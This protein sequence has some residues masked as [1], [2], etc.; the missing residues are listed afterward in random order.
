MMMDVNRPLRN[1][2]IEDAENLVSSSGQTPNSLRH[3]ATFF[4]TSRGRKEQY[5]DLYTP[6][7]VFDF[8]REVTGYIR[9]CLNG[10]SGNM[11]DIGVSERLIDGRVAPLVQGTLNADRYI[12]K[13]GRQEWETF[14]WKGFRYLQLTFRELTEPI[15]LIEVS[16]NITSYPVEIRG[17]FMADEQLHK[18]WE[19]GRYTLECCMH[20]SYMDTPWREQRQWVGDGYIQLL[21]DLSAHGDL[22]L[23]RKFLR[24]VGQSQRDD[25]T[26]LNAVVGSTMGK[27]P[28]VMPDYSLLWVMAIHD[29]FLHTGD[30]ELLA[31]L[32]PKVERLL[33][34]FALYLTNDNIV[35]ELPYRLF[36]DWAPID[37]KGASA[38]LNAFYYQALKVSSDLARILGKA[39]KAVEY[40]AMADSLKQRIQNIFWDEKKACYVDAYDNEKKSDNIS[41]QTNAL[42]ALYEIAQQGQRE[43]L[44]NLLLHPVEGMTRS[45]PYFTFF[46][47]G[48]LAKLEQWDEAIQLIRTKWGG[49]IDQGATTFWEEWQVHGTYRNGRW[50][51]VPRSH[52]HAWSS[53][54]TYFLSRYVLG[55]EP[56]EPGFRTF[57]FQPGRGS[58]QH[59]DGRYPT[60]RGD[61]LVKWRMEKQGIAAEITVP[62]GLTAIIPNPAG[63]TMRVNGGNNYSVLLRNHV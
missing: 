21:V 28:N 22:R 30:K 56:L 4:S 33:D 54:P 45:E 38:A 57:A 43:A 16:V 26:T 48:A 52:C 3:P 63:G 55:I 18:I 9:L 50:F 62:E 14:E 32:F 46:V 47:L 35:G 51:P 17:G 61:I 34:W 49:M 6:Y 12:M 10:K 7:I 25:G 13:D 11:I 40:A 42:M 39:E 37:K 8:E 36:I 15:E 53:G 23:A 27:L 24:Q 58:L 29:Y 41:Q 2:R 1:C 20:D 31:E 44:K 60:P 5:P 59:V 19:M